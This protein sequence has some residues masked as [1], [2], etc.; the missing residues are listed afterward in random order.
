MIRTD[1]RRGVPRFAPL[2]AIAFAFFCTLEARSLAQSGTPLQLQLL[3][4]DLTSLARAAREQGDASRGAIVFY[5]PDLLCMR[6]HSAGDD[7]ARLGPDLARAG[8]EATD[9]Y[10]VESILLPSKVIKK[11]FESVLITTK[12]GKTVTGLLAEDRA[13]AVVLRDAAEPGTLVTIRKQDID[14]R[15]DKGPSLMPEGAVNV[16]SNRQEF[17]DLARYLM[18][19]AEHG[20]ARARQLKPAASLFAPPPVPAYER[21]LDHAGL[22]RAL[23]ARSY[24]RG[25]AIF[26]RVCANCH[27]TREQA[28]SMPTSLRFADGKFKNGADPFHMYQTLT[29]GFGMMTPQG[30]MVPE[31]KYDVIH[32]IREAYLKPHNAGQYTSIDAS[33]LASLP[34]GSARGPKPT[35]IEPWSS[36]NYGPS[37]M[38][39]I[40]VGDQGNFAYKGVA[41][42]LDQGPGGISRGHQW[43]LYDHDTMRA[44]AAW[45]GQGFIDWNGVNFN[46]RHAIHPR[47][48]GTVHFA[49]VAGPGWANPETGRFD[50]VRIKGRDGKAYG[51]LPRSWARYRGV[52][53]YGNQVI[54]SYSVGDAAILEMPAYEIGPDGKVIYTRTLNLGKS[55]REL[56]LRV[57]AAE[58][59]VALVGGKGTLETRDGC[60]LLRIPAQATPEKLALLLSDGPVDALRNFAKGAPPPAALEPFTHGGPR[61][62]PEILKTQPVVGADSGPFAIDVLTHPDNNPWNCQMRLTGFDFFADGRRAAVCTWDGD[63]WLVDGL[64]APGKGLTWQRIASGLFQPL[65]LKIVHGA[66]YVS[67]RDQ[68]VILRDLNGDGE[69]DFYEC[70]N[71]DHQVTEHFH[72]FAMDLQTDA[73]GNFYYTK[74]ARH[75]LKAIVPQHG[76]LLKVD[77]AG[78][79]TEILATGF[80]APNGVCLNPDGTFFLSDQEGFWVPKNRIDRVVPGGYYGNFWGY[81]DI[82]DSSD[83]A[84]KQPL[85]W[86]TNAFDRSPSEQIWVTSKQWGPLHGSLL[87][88]SYGYGK[89]YVVPH[90]TVAGQIQGGMC[91]LP[92]P[93]F[94]TGVMR[95][96]FHPVDGQLYCCGMFAW[97]GDQTQPGGFY[98]IRYTGKPVCLPIGLRARKSGMTIEFS[99]VL[100]SKAASDAKNYAV[101]T[102]SLKRSEQYGSKHYD[103][104][105]AKVTAAEVAADGKTVVLHIEGLKPTWCMEI[106][107][108]LK[109]RDGAPV[110]GVLNNTIH[111]LGE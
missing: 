93:Q 23:D 60:T 107:Y 50:D 85:C 54:L 68:I 35:N 62:W 39:T 42:R 102:W 52:Y 98:R 37:L 4:E 18:E 29:H 33:Y 108:Q 11:G 10:L 48:V 3:A 12:A 41:V 64:D 97:A 27:G 109:G 75:A 78:D 43:M 92:L 14:E 13:D 70:F 100:D 25:E 81:H 9:R 34:N 76:T 51:P 47:P 57:G 2:L 84:M 24:Q 69:T 103:E 30:W 7:T 6:C 46:G 72:E 74:G 89:V 87:N 17:L 45:S 99:G 82:K 56:L 22:I 91:Q 38:A 1:D 20:P 8:K 58:T 61:R 104:K 26:V 66:V 63:V 110:I 28:G 44:V 5:R 21:E 71:D 67:C 94:P 105:P 101:K 77:K 59:A 31:Q 55:T 32:Y 15:S 40:E 73:A 88:F 80:R 106:K 86:I 16:L 49:N 95:G 90:E 65:G 111:H 19:I 53:H 96:R 36:M 83:A 79:H